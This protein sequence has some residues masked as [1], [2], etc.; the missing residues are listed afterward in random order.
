MR[1]A[2]ID[3]CDLCNGLDVGTSLYVQGC[4]AHC[5]NCFNPETW[6]FNGGKQ[7]TMEIE[8]EFFSHISKPYIK[9]VT[10]LG[11]EPL[12]E[13]NANFVA[14][15]VEKI[16]ELYPDKWI[17]VYTGMRFEDV[18]NIAKYNDDVFYPEI[19]KNA[20]RRVLSVADYIVDGEYIDEL[21][22]STIPFRGSTNQKIHERL[23][24]QMDGFAPTYWVLNTNFDKAEK[25]TN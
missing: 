25:E 17:W 8:E 23:V 15:I 22:S 20:I 14:N 7:W 21:H 19:Y 16:R 5:K 11:G 6:D 13:E 9:R 3:K 12:A 10:I 4:H 24:P 1:Y 2:G 18:V